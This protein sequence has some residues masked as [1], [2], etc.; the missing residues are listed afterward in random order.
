[1]AIAASHCAGPHYGDCRITLCEACASADKYM[2]GPVSH[3]RRMGYCDGCWP[4]IPDKREAELDD[5][6]DYSS[7][8]R[9]DDDQS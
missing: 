3:G 9:G 5:I 2:L 1:M 8:H 7:N 4:F 6:Q